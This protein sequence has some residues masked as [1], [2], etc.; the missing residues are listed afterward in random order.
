MGIT[1]TREFKEELDEVERIAYDT[2]KMKLVS[3]NVRER[4]WCVQE[5]NSVKPSNSYTSA[6]RLR[7]KP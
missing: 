3:K 5:G 2:R 1:G 6:Q 7:F 4:S